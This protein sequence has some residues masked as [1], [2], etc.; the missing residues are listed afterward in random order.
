[1]CPDDDSDEVTNDD[2]GKAAKTRL[3]EEVR[4]KE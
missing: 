1:M 2:E 3:C 4:C